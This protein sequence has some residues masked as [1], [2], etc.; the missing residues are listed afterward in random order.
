MRVA[1]YRK[2]ESWSV[3]VRVMMDPPC[4]SFMR[5]L[6]TLGNVASDACLQVRVERKLDVDL[7]PPHTHTKEITK[8]RSPTHRGRGHI[9]SH[10]DVALQEEAAAAVGG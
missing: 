1:G 7:Q 8:E 2:N 4:L 9:I 3:P 6:G 5:L 10:D